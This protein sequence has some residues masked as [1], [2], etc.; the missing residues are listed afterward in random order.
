LIDDL[1]AELGG[2]FEDA[3]VALM[4]ATHSFLAQELR[5]AMKV[6]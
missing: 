4:A 3:V 2:N 5:N 6:N 1:K